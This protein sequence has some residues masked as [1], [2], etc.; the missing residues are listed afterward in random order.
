MSIFRGK[1]S[2][3]AEWIKRFMFGLGRDFESSKK[4]D[5]KSTFI[6]QFIK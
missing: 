5:K 3:K 6:E 2:G 4:L 1:P